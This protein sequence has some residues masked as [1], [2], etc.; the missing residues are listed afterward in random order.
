MMQRDHGSSCVGW[1]HAHQPTPFLVSS[2]AGPAV[3]HRPPHR[4]PTRADT[5]LCARAFSLVELVLVIAIIAIVAG[6]AATRYT[7][8]ARTAQA[9]SILQTL[10]IVRTAVD[11]YYGEHGRYP[12]YN[13][14]DGAP[15][16]RWFV[17]QLT[18]F[19]GAG[20][21]VSRTPSPAFLFGPYLR[22]PFPSN[23]LNGLSTVRVRQS[24]TGTVALNASG[25]IA[26]LD[27]G[28][29]AINAATTK[30]G[31]LGISLETAGLGVGVI[32]GG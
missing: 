31:N 9:N 19:S 25:W 10:E 21:N 7:R 1:R 14:S 20:G 22:N 18:Q 8:G 12:G 16:G 2:R 6:I 28:T 3:S 11:H 26:T 13:P 27:D 30:L 5:G 32:L 29:F 17:D 4:H 24:R 15:D 23:P